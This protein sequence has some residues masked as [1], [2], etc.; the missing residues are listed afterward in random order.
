[1]N[2][3]SKWKKGAGRDTPSQWRRSAK[4]SERESAKTAKETAIAGGRGGRNAP[5]IDRPLPVP[6]TDVTTIAI[7]DVRAHPVS[8]DAAHAAVPSPETLLLFIRKIIKNIFPFPIK[9]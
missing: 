9:F 1:M 8:V 2:G 6:A 4:D 3:R 7:A 5:A